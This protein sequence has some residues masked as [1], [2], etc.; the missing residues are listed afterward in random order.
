MT[1]TK[2]EINARKAGIDK[3]KSREELYIE[4]E[5]LFD[6][7]TAESIDEILNTMLTLSL[8]HPDD[9]FDNVEKA[10]LLMLVDDLV[11]LMYVLRDYYEAYVKKE[12]LEKAAV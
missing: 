5:N 8:S 7:Q 2:K 1:T 9:L 4:L 3:K 6:F 12:E 11:Y 10:N